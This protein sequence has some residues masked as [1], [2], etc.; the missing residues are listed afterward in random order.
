MAKKIVGHEIAQN[1]VEKEFEQTALPDIM[2]SSYVDYAM[3]VI[4]DRALPDVRDGLKPVQRR[5][6]YAMSDMKCFPSTPHRKSARIVGEVM[7]KYHPHGDSSIY[8]ASVYMAQPFNMGM[9]LI[10]GHG[11]FGSMDGDGPAAS[12]YTEQ[13]LS[14]VAMEMI[15]D[16]N[17]NTVDFVPNFD[18]EE[19]E[20]V[21]LPARFPNLLVNG[22]QGIAVGMATN[23]PPH[24]LGE[25]CDATCLMI[26]N[27]IHDKETD[28]SSLLDIVKGP[29]FPTGA[30]ILGRSYRDMYVN[31][32]G[33]VEMEAVWHTETEGKKEIIVFTEL[34]FQVNKADLVADIAKY[35]KEKKL[36]IVDVRDES[37]REG[38]RV[39][40]ECKRNAIVDL[41]INNLLQHTRLRCSYSANMMCL[42]D[43]KPVQLGLVPM[44]RYYL[45]HQIEVVRRRT[46]FEKKKAEDRKHIV[47][48]LLIAIDNI[49]EVI[50]I[51]KN[52]KD[53]NEAKDQLMMRFG[54]SEVQAQTI[55][56][57]RIRSLTGLERQ[58]LEDELASL[59]VEI[60]RCTKVLGDH[61]ELLKLIK[62]E[63]KEIRKKYAVDRKTGHKVEYSDITMED[64]IEDEPCVIIRTNFGY[65]KRMKPGVFRTQKKGGKGSHVAKLSDDYIED[66]ISTSLLADIIF[67]TNF[68]RVYTM[69]AYQIAETARTSRG[70]AL[71]SILTKLQPGEQVTGMIAENEY[72]DDKYLMMITKNGIIKRTAMSALPRVRSNGL[73]MIKLDDGD[74]VRSTVVVTESDNV[75]ITTRHGY[76]V[77]YPVTNVRSMGRQAHGVKGLRL[78]S[79]DEVV[80]MQRQEMGREVVI[81]TERGYAKR[82]RCEDFRLFKNRTARGNRA[83]KASAEERIGNVSKA[84]LVEDVSNDLIITMDNGQIIKTPIDK[85]PVYSRQAMG[86]RMINLS[87]NP[88]GVVAD[89]VATVHEEPND[90]IDEDD[91]DEDN[92]GNVETNDVFNE[93]VN[94]SFKNDGVETV[95]NGVFDGE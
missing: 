33:R 25:V 30:M 41:I 11:N 13:R 24:N 60:D 82:V 62:K 5:I 56:D 59:V 45:D 64:L 69:K 84:F 70:T 18:G 92:V 16:I 19:K 87:G 55:L 2:G 71:V 90:D 12:R 28:L 43:G 15:R 22:S 21:V 23:I 9:C 94:D 46:E 50:E 88:D 72:S 89:V 68:G 86:T 48:G 34:P 20:P 57:L 51:A 47:E 54:L 77:G 93:I 37:S 26:D 6:L 95:E 75:M 91:I 31:G 8:G 53:Q 78:T 49:D 1:V 14:K 80:S 61:K 36:D 38:L 32:K 73:F 44:L 63:L 40:V 42:A 76:C 74:E 17:C 81:I 66:M 3:S 35:A 7:G 52:C 79:G 58:K 67:F 27:D 10:D 39:V 29:D 83:I 65:L 85:I 4:T